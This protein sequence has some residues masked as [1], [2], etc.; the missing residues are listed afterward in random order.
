MLSSLS[1]LICIAA[2]SAAQ[3]FSIMSQLLPYW[4]YGL[5]IRFTFAKESV[6]AAFIVSSD[7]GIVQHY[8][9]LI[10]L[11]MLDTLG[12]VWKLLSLVIFEHKQRAP[13]KLK[14]IVSDFWYSRIKKKRKK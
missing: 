13:I 9:A 10:G 5:D 2:A 7:M 11:N 1:H 4:L 12:S 6:F 14:S 8:T 3:T